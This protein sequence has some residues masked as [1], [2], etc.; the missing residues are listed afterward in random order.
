MVRTKKCINVQKFGFMV[1]GRLVNL[2][3]ETKEVFRI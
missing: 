3:L 2:V 1:L